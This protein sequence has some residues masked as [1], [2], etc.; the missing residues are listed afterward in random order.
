MKQRRCPCA[1]VRHCSPGCQWP[2]VCCRT[3]QQAWMSASRRASRNVWSCQAETAVFRDHKI[4][5]HDQI[6]LSHILKTAIR[7]PDHYHPKLIEPHF[8]VGINIWVFKTF[9]LPILFCCMGASQRK[10]DVCRVEARSH[11]RYLYHR[12]TCSRP[13]ATALRCLVTSESPAHL[14]RRPLLSRWARCWPGAGVVL[15][16]N[17]S[18]EV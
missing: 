14:P 2:V 11:L 18:N 17:Y 9:S 1:G 5:L 6:S 7:E 8:Q 15:C 16:Q 3:Q 13:A 4:R 12:I 10:T